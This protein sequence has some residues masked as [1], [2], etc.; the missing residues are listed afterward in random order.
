MRIGREETGTESIRSQMGVVIREGLSK[1][2]S[3]T[4]GCTCQFMYD[5]CTHTR[6]IAGILLNT[7]KSKRYRNFIGHH[8][9]GRSYDVIY[10][11]PLMCPCLHKPYI[12]LADRQT[13][14]SQ[15][16]ETESRTTAG[17]Q[18]RSNIEVG[19]FYLHDMYVIKLT[20]SIN[21]APK[22]DI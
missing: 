13:G 5:V 11:G 21:M 8:I 3:V 12:N 18:K 17:R 15:C 14:R 22:V 6:F 10:D 19:Y 9:S 16:S 7:C 1:M 2:T 20:F 4:H